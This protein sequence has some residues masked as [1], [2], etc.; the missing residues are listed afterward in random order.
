MSTLDRL[1]QIVRGGAAPRH[2][3][4]VRELT[5]EPVGPDGLP[6][7]RT[8]SP[9]LAG[10]TTVQTPFGM[11]AV[12]E[13]AFDADW[14]FGS[15]CVHECD[16]VEPDALA[17]LTGRPVEPR[18]TTR[19]APLFLDLETTGL[20]G[21]AGTV[22]FLV[23]C[24]WFERGAFRTTQFFL[25]G[26]AAE[27]ALL[28]L[29]ADLL[30]DVPFIVTYNGRTFDLPVMEMRWQFHRI[31]APL[32]GLPHVDMLPPARR[33]WKDVADGSD[34]SCRLVHLEEALL[35]YR[36]EGEVAAFEIPQRYFAFIR[37]G[38]P[39]PLEP[40]LQHN[41]LDLLSLAALTAR[42]QRLIG[43]GADS[44]ADACE[45]LSLGR[46]YRRANHFS[47]AEDCFRRVAAE[48]ETGRMVREAA[49]HEL[50]TLLRRQRRFREAAEAWRELIALGHGRSRAA[51]V[52]IEALAVHHEHRERNLPRARD[53]AMCALRAEQDMKRR[54]AV[55]YRLARLDRKLAFLSARGLLGPSLLEPIDEGDDGPPCRNSVGES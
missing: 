44:A 34:R 2:P 27:R 47:R 26:F 55:R 6:L 12:I 52:A 36:R 8:L 41:R 9:G 4:P 28:H 7:D 42:A 30:A 19:Q 45:C 24:G 43:R 10:A 29:V 48:A 3:A 15:I 37:Y 49:L 14:R 5:Y 53:L 39:Q 13:R 51:R 21:G 35:G 38:D 22:A 18:M 23:G 20:S 31:T 1:R 25:N 50:A 17:L 33:L 54:D 46:L 32:D 16:V 11:A 40:V